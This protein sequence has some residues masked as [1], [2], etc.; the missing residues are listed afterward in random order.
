MKDLICEGEKTLLKALE[1]IDQNGKRVLFV[2]DKND[3]FIGV[4]TDGDVRRFI[5]AEKPLN[6]PIREIVKNKT[7]LSARYGTSITELVKL[8]K[9]PVKIIPLLDNQQRVVDYF[10]LSAEFHAPIASTELNGNELANVIECITTNWISSQGRFVKAFEDGFASYIG[11]KHGVAVMNGTVALHLA[12]RALDIGPGDEVIVPDLTFAATINAVLY[13][14]ATPVLVDVEKES[15]SIDPQL[16]EE[17]IS[18]R[19][20]AIIPVHLYGQPCNMAAIM[21]LAERYGLFVVEDC[22]EAHGAE[23]DGY[24]VG[25]FG[26]INCFSFYANKILTTGEGGMCLTNNSELATKMCLLRDHGMRPGKRYWHDFV[27]FNYRMTNLQAAVGVAQL[28]RIDQILSKRE[29]IHGWYRARLADCKDFVPQAVIPR[30]KSVT[31]LVSYMI[32]G[33]FCDRDMLIELAA[34]RRIDIRPFFNSLSAMPLYA[35]YAPKPPEVS[36]IL[37]MNGFSLPTLVSLSE[38]D[39]GF[40]TSEIRKIADELV[41]VQE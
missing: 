28:D 3:R 23:F 9:P 39:Y 17:A 11:V 32:Q 31:W 41:A 36:K 26:H 22:A 13:V 8:A 2:V 19:T 27:G 40:I 33:P 24:K 12:L 30:R 37:A 35:A 29:E 4:L 20:R 18:P 14:G 10:E 5:L 34:K 6:T 1:Q 15:W 16:I 21:D 38:E 7:S 25:G